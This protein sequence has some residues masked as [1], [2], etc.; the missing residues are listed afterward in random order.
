MK[1]PSGRAL[2][3][4][5][6]VSLALGTIVFLSA[7]TIDY[8]EAWL[9]L[10]VVTLAGIA[11]VVSM[12]DTDTDPDLWKRRSDVGHDG[13]PA[14]WQMAVPA[15]GTLSELALF[16]MP[17]LDH[18]FRWSHV[19]PIICGMGDAMMVLGIYGKYLVS[20]VDI[21]AST[22]ALARAQPF[23]VRTG[24]Y[25]FV[26]HPMLTATLVCVS[27]VPLALDS[28]IGTLFL[29]PLLWMVV[30]IVHAEEH[31]LGRCLPDYAEYRE[32][33]KWRLI[34]YVW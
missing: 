18:R 14:A 7:W 23:T 31:T 15:V 28:W 22:A 29:A 6:L 4:Q 26:R 5:V 1:W 9:F 34:P 2:S 11:W 24:L 13:V 12:P 17:G 3:R 30:V 33:V 10:L 16:V 21:A 19:P 25:A 8:P 32:Q 27:G 20:K